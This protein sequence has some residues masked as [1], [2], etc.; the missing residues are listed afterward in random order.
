MVSQSTAFCAIGESGRGGYTR[1]SAAR[2][3]VV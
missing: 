1:C 3:W 2:Y